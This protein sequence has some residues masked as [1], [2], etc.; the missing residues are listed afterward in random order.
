MSL[1]DRLFPPYFR[2]YWMR[3][4]LRRVHYADRP[5]KLDRL[6]RM[7]DPWRLASPKEQ[8]R[9]EWTNR[10]IETHLGAPEA[11]LEIGSGE[12]YQ[13]QH[14]ARICRR[15]Y[16]IDVS[17]RAVDRA[18]QRCPDVRFAAA[19]P[20]TFRFDDAPPV[21]DLIVACEMLYYVRDIRRFIERMSQ[22][23]RA[24]LVTYYDGQ[25]PILDPH[26]AGLPAFQR[27]ALRVK[28]VMWHAAWWR[29]AAHLP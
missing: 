17:R 16:G 26:F 6:Y 11:I 13:S 19:N 2:R 25:A 18:R 7:E 1:I 5:D 20:L 14:L 8:A 10:L 4:A 24:C 3:R 15:L 9:Y 29:T 21:Y 28:G 27:D 22:L 23:G 12:G